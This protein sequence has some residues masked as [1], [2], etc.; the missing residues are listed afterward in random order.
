M[1]EKKY[2]LYLFAAVGVIHII[3]SLVW[4]IWRLIK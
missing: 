2:V 4:F 1:S 3:S